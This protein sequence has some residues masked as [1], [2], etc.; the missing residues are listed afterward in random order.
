MDKAD[1][2]EWAPDWDDDDVETDF[3][4]QLRAELQKAIDSQTKS[5]GDP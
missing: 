5:A 1:A 3:D 4:K 2:A